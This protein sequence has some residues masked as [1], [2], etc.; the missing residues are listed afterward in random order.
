MAEVI[1]KLRI[2]PETPE[3]D[4]TLIHHEAEKR[5]IGFG[6]QLGKTVREPVAFG[7]EALVIVFVMDESLGSTEPLEISLSRIR[8]V[9]SVDIEDVRRA[10][11]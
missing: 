11:F 2:M 6:G 8:G 3:T 10:I 5:I 4:L 9:S 7:L 1:V